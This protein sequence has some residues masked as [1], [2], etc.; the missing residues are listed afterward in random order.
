MC[1]YKRSESNVL[2]TDSCNKQDGQALVVLLFYMIIAITLSTTAVA[3][4]LSNS[5]SVT[6]NEEGVHALEIAEAGAENALIRLMRATDYSGEILTVGGGNATVTVGGDNFI[7][8]A[9]STGVVGDFSRTVQVTA[10]VDNGV[11][12]VLSWEEL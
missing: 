2:H 8:I 6:R 4:L 10:G 1:R 12:T 5:L 11:L 3:V 7:K 9:T